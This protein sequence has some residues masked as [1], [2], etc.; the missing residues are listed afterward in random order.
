MKK[1]R[2]EN[3]RCTVTV[4][5]TVL[6]VG[7]SAGDLTWTSGNWNTTD[8]SWRDAG[9]NTVAFASGDNV[10]FASGGSLSLT[11]SVSPG[12]VTFD[13]P[14]GK[15]LTLTINGGA[16]I[17]DSATA[18]RKTGGG[19]L[20]LV[21]GNAGNMN[22][23]IAVTCGVEVAQGIVE[24][25]TA[26][27][28][29]AFN[30]NAENWW[31]VKSGA[32]LKLMDRN[33]TGNVGQPLTHPHTFNLYVENGGTLYFYSMTSGNHCGNAFRRL[34]MEG[35]AILD[36]AA[37]GS[38][39]DYGLIHVGE[40]FCA[41]GSVPL[42]VT[43]NS[44]YE[45]QYLCVDW[46]AK[47]V[48]FD[49]ADITGD[50]QTDFFLEMPF[51]RG[52]SDKTGIGFVKRGSGRMTLT[53][54]VDGGA[55]L[56]PNG[57][58]RIEEGTLSFARQAQLAPQFDR[59][60]YAGTNAVLHYAKRNIQNGNYLDD[61]GFNLKLVIDHGALL[62]DDPVDL[63]GHNFLGMSLTLVDG[64]VSNTMLGAG[65]GVRNYGLMTFGTNVTLKGTKPYVFKPNATDSSKQVVHL[66]GPVPT[67]FVVDDITG[68]SA[69]D[70]TI[71]YPLRNRWNSYHS[72]VD[73]SLSRHERSGL[74]KSGAGTLCLTSRGNSFTGDVAVCEGTLLL[75]WPEGKTEFGLNDQTILGDMTLT[76]R[77][78]TVYTN[79]TLALAQRNMFTAVTYAAAGNNRL[80]TPIIL[81]GGTLTLVDANGFG[82]LTVEN[83]R[84][85]YSRGGG[86]GVLGMHGTFKVAGT[87]PCVL[88]TV[89]SNPFLFLYPDKPA[90]FDVDDVTGDARTD[91]ELGLKVIQPP[92]GSIRDYFRTNFNQSVYGFVK[93]GAGTMAMTANHDISSSFN[94]DAVV[95]NGT[96]AVD[97]NIARS[98]TVRVK[99]G[100][101]LAGTGTVNNVAIAAAGG[102]RQT[103]GNT[104]PLTISGNLSIGANPV[105]RIDNPNGLSAKS[106]KAAVFSAN[107]TVTG[108]E[109]LHNATFYL[110][111]EL[112]KP[113]TWIALYATGRCTV[114]AQ[115]GTML[116]IK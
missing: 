82:D 28:I 29:W 61:T 36:I 100:A 50:D 113:G 43:G 20:V 46:G 10:T 41:T 95:S 37:K 1:V 97:G 18:F 40:Y 24:L 9:G 74:V 48:T 44:A 33:V 55:A 94:G 91:L 52:G 112:Q 102:F 87:D 69:V 90:V 107:G 57:D 96:L 51:V 80:R 53:D 32:T 62:I 72:D 67:E 86:W 54:K 115:S 98:D 59:T 99:E 5:V 56:F 30:G 93:V 11:A 73:A 6:C 64:V 31:R 78:V 104:R 21:S 85:A 108:T 19:T 63:W 103:A 12:D 2:V 92:D 81:K 106:I 25:R 68:D 49:V 7:L 88:P 22:L 111:G 114:K 89:S 105:F 110:D 13:I 76:N 4:L 77:A 27:A 65:N 17:L 116:V 45:N 35:G 79:G 8:A 109:N 60:V 16:K 42:T 84:I 47:P 66:W 3:R 75:D 26:N 34:V 15:T 58:I 39:K 38:G 70:A 101:F 71:H 14:T 83:G 23:G